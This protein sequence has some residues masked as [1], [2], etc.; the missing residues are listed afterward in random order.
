MKNKHPLSVVLERKER[1]GSPGTAEGGTLVSGE[2]WRVVDVLCTCGP[3]DRPFEERYWSV[4]VSLVLSGAFVY[5]T[6]LGSVL[7][8][9]GAW[10]LGNLGGTYEC[11]HEHGQGDRCLSFQF[12]PALFD[13]IA[14]D[15][16]VS[17]PLFRSSRV[18]PLRAITPLAARAISA[19]HGDGSFE[20]VAF[21]IAAGMLRIAGDL[22]SRDVTVAAHDRSRIVEVLHHLERN[23]ARPLRLV[24]LAAL[25][26]LSP[27]HFLRTFKAVTGVTPH[28]WLIRARLCRAAQRLATSEQ[29]ITDIAFDVGFEDLSNFIRSFRAQFG[30][31]PGR[32]RACRPAHRARAARAF[33]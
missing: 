15:A 30:V 22:R 2:G 28:Q 7:M 16:G 23:A 14:R 31:P 10:L 17:T 25:V 11:S 20:E 13:R 27:C 32:Y 26:G 3:A 6:S 21:E 29:A 19:L 12:D 33:C 1:E 24:D 18:P 9:P 4:A 5:R 8:S